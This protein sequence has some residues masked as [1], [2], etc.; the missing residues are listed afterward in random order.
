[1]ATV[2]SCTQKEESVSHGR[3]QRPTLAPPLHAHR[4]RLLLGGPRDSSLEAEQD[5]EGWVLPPG[6]TEEGTG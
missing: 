6:P 1:M 2:V 3:G 5:R 4:S